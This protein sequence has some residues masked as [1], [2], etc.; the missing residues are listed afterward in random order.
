M[1]TLLLA[2]DTTGFITYLYTR[3]EASFGKTK[4]L[5]PFRS[6]PW[7][8]SFSMFRKIKIITEI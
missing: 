1:Q 5:Y 3:K 4:F 2:S 7:E 6:F 8:Q